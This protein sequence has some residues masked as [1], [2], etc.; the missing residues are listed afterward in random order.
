[1]GM[2]RAVAAASTGT[3]LSMQR[4]AGRDV[5]SSRSLPGVFTV[6]SHK[7]DPFQLRK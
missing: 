4:R 5:T 6:R 2:V 7:S 1:M 3:C